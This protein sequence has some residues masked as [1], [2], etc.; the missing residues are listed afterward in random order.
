MP[1]TPRPPENLAELFANP[2]RIRQAWRVLA[3]LENL[4]IVVVKNGVRRTYPLKL[5]ETNAL[6][7]IDVS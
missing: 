3:A 6:L 5:G 2:E 4:Q 1:K 7:E